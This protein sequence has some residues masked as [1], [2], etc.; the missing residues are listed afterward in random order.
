MCHGILFDCN[1]ATSPCVLTC[2]TGVSGSLT[3][4]VCLCLQ[5]EFLI[6]YDTHQLATPQPDTPAVRP[7][8]PPLPPAVLSLEQLA[9]TA[10]AMQSTE[11]PAGFLAMQAAVDLM[12]SLASQGRHSWHDASPYGHIQVEALHDECIFC[13]S[14]TEQG[15]G[16]A[17]CRVMQ[18]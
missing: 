14:H 13:T 9:A 2:S 12:L 7:P 5:D 11:H 16:N 6:V 1:E 17:W 10:A 3:M 4:A 18:L 8:S 15:A